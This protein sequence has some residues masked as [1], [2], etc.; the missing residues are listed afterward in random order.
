[1]SELWSAI[2][3]R[4]G[5]PPALE[6]VRRQLDRAAGLGVPAHVTIL[7]PWLPA[8]AL[9][10]GARAALDAIAGETRAFDVRFGEARRWP[11]IVYLEPDP[12]APFSALIERVVARFPDLLPYGGTVQDVIPHLTV[13]ENAYAALDEIA[14]QA[15]RQLPFDRSIRAIEVL[16]EGPAGRWQLRWRLPLKDSGVRP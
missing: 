9:T 8:S 14:A 4:I 13:V 3:V 11:D 15:A 1:M 6:R 7:Y 2:V 10:D 5:L 16:V 12:A